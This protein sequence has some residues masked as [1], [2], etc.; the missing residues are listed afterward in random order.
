MK[1]IYERLLVKP[2]C[3]R[4]PQP[5]GDASTCHQHQEQQRQWILVSQRLECYRGQSWRSDSGP[6]EEPR[7]SCMDPRHWTLCYLI[8]MEFSFA[9]FRLRLCSSSCLTTKVFDLILIFTGT[10]C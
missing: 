2:N 8:L 5:F 1:G 4:R 7:S 10:H 6:L 9:W 3:S